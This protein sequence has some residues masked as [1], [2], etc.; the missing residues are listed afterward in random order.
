MHT[1]D[2]DG[3]DREYSRM[4]GKGPIDI[5]RLILRCPDL[6]D[7]ASSS[8]G[9]T[10]DCHFDI[11]YGMVGRYNRRTLSVYSD[12]LLAVAGLASLMQKNYNLTYAAGLWKEDLQAGLCWLASSFLKDDGASNDGEFLD[13]LAPTSSWASVRSKNLVYRGTWCRQDHLPEEGIQLL[14]LEVSHRPG[15]LAAFGCITFARLTVCA[16]LQMVLVP[17]SAN[18]A[19]LVIGAKDLRNVSAVDLFTDSYVGSVY[20]DLLSMRMCPNDIDIAKQ[21]PIAVQQGMIPL[22]R[23]F[24]VINFSQQI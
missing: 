8:S 19:F 18:P 7:K 23:L 14:G 9:M 4:M 15:A 17:R 13:Y 5:V 21:S 11:W 3:N 6:F 12:K 10:S 1:S 20:L 24:V 16:R 2:P 22:T